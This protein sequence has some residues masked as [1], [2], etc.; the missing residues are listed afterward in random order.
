M[1]EIENK[2]S[3]SSLIS[4]DLED[5]YNKGDREVYD[6]RQNLFQDI[7]LKEKDFRDFIKQHNWEIYQG[8][9]VAIICSV[10]AVIPTWAYML[11]ITKISP[12]ANRVVL[13]DL[14]SLEMVLF[15]D[16][17]EIID[18]TKFKDARVVIKGCGKYPVSLFAY[19][20]ITNRLLPY[21]QSIMYGEPCST[22]PVF[23]KSTK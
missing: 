10:D 13:G 20:E 5:Y 19:G 4:F 1:K 18:Y 2:V 22:V 8:K 12:F 14:A 16:A 11:L 3:N 7:I 9:N 21:V 23:K 15:K 6:I 17:L